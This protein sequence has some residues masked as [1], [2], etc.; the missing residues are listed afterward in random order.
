[1][2]RTLLFLLLTA[3]TWSW[4]KAQSFVPEFHNDKIKVRPVVAL[5]SYAFNLKDL[6]LLDGPFKQAAD[7]DAK[8]LLS[9]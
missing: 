2:K 7:A 5:E 3:T 4:V 8:Y 6:R 9:L 1:M